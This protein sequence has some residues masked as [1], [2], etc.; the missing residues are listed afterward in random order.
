MEVV[1]DQGDEAFYDRLDSAYPTDDEDTEVYVNFL[2][3]FSRTT[4]FSVK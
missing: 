3:S 2:I 1:E 4:N